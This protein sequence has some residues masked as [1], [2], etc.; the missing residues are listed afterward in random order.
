MKKGD[1]GLDE[2]DVVKLNLEDWATGGLRKKSEK[3][4]RFQP[5]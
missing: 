1:V 3:D 5:E 2:R 4:D